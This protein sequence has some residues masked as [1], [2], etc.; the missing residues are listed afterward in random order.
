MLGAEGVG[1]V[2]SSTFDGI[3]RGQVKSGRKIDGTN[4][5]PIPLMTV[6]RGCK[7]NLRS[8]TG[9]WKLNYESDRQALGKKKCYGPRP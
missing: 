5:V 7:P 8:N 2:V 3:G 9:V 6:R 1:G 4:D